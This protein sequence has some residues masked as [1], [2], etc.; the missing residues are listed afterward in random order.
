MLIG[1]KRS[2]VYYK[3]CLKFVNKILFSV[4]NKNLLK[5]WTSRY[6]ECWFQ[7]LVYSLLGLLPTRGK[8]KWKKTFLL[9]YKIVLID[10]GT[11]TIVLRNL[12]MRPYGPALN[13]F[14]ST[15]CDCQRFCNHEGT[16]NKAILINVLIRL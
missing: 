11:K 3:F 4:K 10:T 1:S 15:R 9:F 2:H 5:Q 14:L 13:T 16:T 6:N 8:N 12:L 7:L